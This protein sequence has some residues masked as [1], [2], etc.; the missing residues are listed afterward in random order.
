MAELQFLQNGDLICGRY[1]TQIVSKGLIA[2]TDRYI[3]AQ[4]I[5]TP[6]PQNFFGQI[7]YFHP[8]AFWEPNICFHTTG[9]K[10]QNLQITVTVSH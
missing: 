1:R 5:W 8:N 6:S 9:V 2:G 7:F 10:G 4:N 3:W